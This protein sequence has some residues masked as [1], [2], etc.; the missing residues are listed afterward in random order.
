MSVLYT[1][2]HSNHQIDDFIKLLKTHLI[3]A[4][5]DVR[6]HPYSRHFPQFCKQEIKNSLLVAGIEYVYL[7]KELGA[8]S[9][10]PGCYINGKVQYDLLAKDPLFSKGI[11]RLL[12]GME[13]FNIALMCAEKDPLQ[14]HRAIL[15]ARQ[16]FQQGVAVQHIHAD[17]SLE[18]HAQMEQRMMALNKISDVDMFHSKEEILQDAYKIHGQKIAYQDEAMLKEELTHGAVI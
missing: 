8:R 13:K 6:S 1:I 12:Q 11:Q 10:N 17:G 15:V 7:G 5:V 14:C 4:L 18:G 2:G 16:I 9:N 3:T